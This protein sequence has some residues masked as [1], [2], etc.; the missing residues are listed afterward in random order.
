MGEK[1]FTSVGLYLTNVVK[2]KSAENFLTKQLVFTI[3]F[4]NFV[5]AWRQG[6]A[7]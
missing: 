7:H 3:S 1:L 6:E 4:I 5:C 2:E